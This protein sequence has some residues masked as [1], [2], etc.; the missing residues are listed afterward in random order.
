MPSVLTVVK[1]FIEDHWEIEASLNPG[2]SLPNEIFVYENSGGPQLGDFFGTCSLAE[3][4][5][6]Q[7]FTGQAIPK[8]ANKYLRY[9]QAKIIVTSESDVQGVITALVNNVKSLGQ[10]FSSATP[11]THSYQ[12]P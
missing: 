11:E 7:I 1:T 4:Q 6:L 2:G 3:L 5:R 12:I 9:G 10:A 8:F